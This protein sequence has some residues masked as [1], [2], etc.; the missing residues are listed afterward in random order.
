VCTQ[1]PVGHFIS[2]DLHKSICIIVGLGSA[3]RSKRKFADLILN[4]LKCEFQYRTQPTAVCLSDDR[5]TTTMMRTTTTNVFQN[6]FG[7]KINFSI[8]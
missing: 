7:G 3:V 2:Q 5:I 1:Q 6:L 4:S 8:T